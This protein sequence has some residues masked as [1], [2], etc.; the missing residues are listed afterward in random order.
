MRIFVTGGCGFIGS[1]FA[2]ML[3]SIVDEDILI[4]DKMTYAASTN[5]IIDGLV[6]FEFFNFTPI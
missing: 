3:S 5:N 6:S 1:N 2:N 4:F